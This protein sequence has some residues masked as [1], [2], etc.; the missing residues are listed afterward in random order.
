LQAL[1]PLQAFAPTHWPSPAAY[2]V[3]ETVAPARNKVA[4]AMAS[5]APDLESNFMTIS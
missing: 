5:V 4:A 2:D 3:V 1:W